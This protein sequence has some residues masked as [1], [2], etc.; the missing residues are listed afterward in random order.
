M[1]KLKK[2]KQGYVLEFDYSLFRKEKKVQREPERPTNVEM[3]IKE[4][5]GCEKLMKL[6]INFQAEKPGL[7]IDRDYDVCPE[8]K[9]D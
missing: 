5:T 9:G 7:E 6:E 3:Y 4:C 8:C 2:I 1:F